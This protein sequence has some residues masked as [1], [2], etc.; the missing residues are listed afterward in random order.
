[1]ETEDGAAQ[2]PD[3]VRDCRELVHRLWLRLP[4]IELGNI[5]DALTRC[6]G[7]P[8]VAT[9]S[10]TTTVH[11]GRFD[12][13]LQTDEFDHLLDQDPTSRS[14]LSRLPFSRTTPTRNSRRNDIRRRGSRSSTEET[15]SLTSLLVDT[16]DADLLGDEGISMLLTASNTTAAAATTTEQTDEELRAEEEAIRLEEEAA[17]EDRRRKAAQKVSLVHMASNRDGI[18]PHQRPS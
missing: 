7:F 16:T 4:A 18:L 14:F 15:S 10:N 1:M 2:R 8:I 12:F 5:Y 13:G 17:I 9:S 3:K 6:L 11:D